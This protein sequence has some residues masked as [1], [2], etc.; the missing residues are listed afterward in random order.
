MKIVRKATEFQILTA[1]VLPF[2]PMLGKE[3]RVVPV[4]ITAIDENG[5]EAVFRTSASES[6]FPRLLKNIC[7]TDSFIKLIK[8]QDDDGTEAWIKVKKD[9]VDGEIE[10]PNYVKGEFDVVRL[11]NND[12][13]EEAISIL[14]NRDFGVGLN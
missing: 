5:N 13:I 1:T 2:L 10:N 11:F 8:V 6:K 3:E 4:I 9:Y 14:Q 7:G 12:P